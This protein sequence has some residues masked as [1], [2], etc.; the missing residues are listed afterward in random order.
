MKFTKQLIF[1]SA[2][3]ITSAMSIQAA[4]DNVLSTIQ[5]EWARCQY[6]LPASASKENC[7]EK[8]DEQAAAL[9]A[10]EPTRNDLKVWLAIVKST[11]AGSKG[12]LG[13]LSLVKQAKVL[14]EEVIAQDPTVLDGSAYTSLGSLYYQV[15][16]WPVSFGDNEKAEALLKKA[17]QINP[18]GI[19]PNYFYADYL[20]SEGKKAQAKTYFEKALQA[21]ARP[22]RED[23]DAGRRNE[24]NEK[25]SEINK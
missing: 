11:Y 18:N 17:L 20:L 21:P 8:L 6:K 16:G 5:H 23:A 1:C 25:L 15:P 12:G 13:A 9:Q 4:D 22:G 24:I 10:K 14:L 3:F 7:F 2:I 19:D